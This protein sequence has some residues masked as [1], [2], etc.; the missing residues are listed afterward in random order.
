[1]DGTIDRSRGEE[2]TLGRKRMEK[3][4]LGV[5]E[6]IVNRVTNVTGS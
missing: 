5:Q 2:K 3:S 6:V 1:M 4:G